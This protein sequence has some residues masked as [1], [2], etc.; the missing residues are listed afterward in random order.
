MTPDEVWHR[1][2]PV[3]HSC[4]WA[5]QLSM[6]TGAVCGPAQIGKMILV[7]KSG[8]HLSLFSFNG[9]LSD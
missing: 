9:H 4:V 6:P 2:S 1:F 7:S 8:K 3:W 5:T